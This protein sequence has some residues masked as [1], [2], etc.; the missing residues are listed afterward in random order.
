M[1][2][3]SGQAATAVVLLTVLGLGDHV[4]LRDAGYLPTL[5]LA[6]EFLAPRGLAYPVYPRAP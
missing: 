6:R 4:L 5:A 2:L 3:P 1:T